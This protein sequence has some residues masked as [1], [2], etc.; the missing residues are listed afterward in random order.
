MICAKMYRIIGCLGYIKPI[1]ISSVLKICR[2]LKKGM[3]TEKIF[4]PIVSLLGVWWAGPYVQCSFFSI[5]A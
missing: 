4:Q 2:C 3:L 1:D 5:M